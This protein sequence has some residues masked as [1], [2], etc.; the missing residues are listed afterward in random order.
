MLPTPLTRVWSSRARLTVVRLARRARAKA[1]SSK[2]ASSGSRA[3]WASESGVA[4]G[5]P[6]SASSTARPPKVRWSTKRSSV[7]PSA[8]LSRARRCTESAISGSWTRSW[9]LMPR[10]PIIERPSPSGTH[11][12]LP[13]RCGSPRVRPRSSAVNSS[14]PPAWRRTAR[15]CS[16]WTSATVRP[17]AQRARPRRTTST[18]GSSG[19]AL[20]S[21][22]RGGLAR[23][24][25]PRGLVLG[26]DGA[27]GGLGGLLPG[28]LLRAPAA[29]AVVRAGFGDHV[30][31]DA[32]ADGGGELLEAGL[33]V[34]SGAELRGFR[35][36][37]IE[38]AVDE[39]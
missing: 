5:S 33:P 11:R 1:S 7:P 2:R 25:G 4:S 27:P 8:N 38:Q 28:F 30:L 23:G 13:R 22:R 29:G 26:L 20:G 10:W 6:A 37:R 36:Q 3:M 21:D 14:A 16:T 34:E 18:S 19:T 39:L 15:G 24:G 17:A 9:P 32:Q 31:G 35:D 12:Y